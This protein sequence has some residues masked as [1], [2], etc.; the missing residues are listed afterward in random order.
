MQRAMRLAWRGWGR[1]QPNPLVG[2]VVLTRTARSSAKVARRVRRTRTPS[3]AALEAAGP[4]AQGGDAGG[5]ARALRAPG[6]AATLHRGDSRGRHRAR[7]LRAAGP[8][9]RGR[10][11]QRELLAG[12]GVL[13]DERARTSEAAAQNAAFLH[14]LAVAGAALRGAQARHQLDGRIADYDRALALDLRGAGAR[15]RPLAARRVRRDRRRRRD[16]AGR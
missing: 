2:A 10:R 11:R 7:G 12:G 5:H 1:V 4:A 3:A 13:V 8:E 14:R 6:Q 16:R 15:M 9:P